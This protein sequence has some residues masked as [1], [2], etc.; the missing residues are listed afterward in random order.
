MGGTGFI[1]KWLT[2]S[3]GFAKESGFNIDISIMSRNPSI[4]EREFAGE[5]FEITWIEQ[6]VTKNPNSD[7]SKFTHIINGA[8]PSSA[9]TGAIDPMYVYN[10]ILGGN[11]FFLNGNSPVDSRYLFLSSGAVSKLEQDE[12]KFDRTLCEKNHLD[13]LTTAYAHGKRF[14]EADITKAIISRGINAQSLRLFAFAGPGLPL[15]QH[16][17]AGNFLRDYLESGDIEIKGNP[18]TLRSYMY[19]TDLTAHLLKSLASI[20]HETVEIGSSEVV[21]MQDLAQIIAGKSDSSKVSKGDHS[22]SASKYFPTSKN[23]LGQTVD[24]EESFKRWKKWL[25]TSKK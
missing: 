25:A 2:A 1:G 23:L 3:L 22:Q 14:A 19:P 17:A 7:L 24:L 6:D 5:G 9:G 18:E 8:T 16:F 10:S 11:N 13:S 20:S 21:S 15:D 4:H 12:E